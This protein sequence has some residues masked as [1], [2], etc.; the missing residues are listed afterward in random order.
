MIT[1]GDND[2]RLITLPLED[3]MLQ[4]LDK[5]EKIR[6]AEQ[7]KHKREHLI[8]LGSRQAT[9]MLCKTVRYLFSCSRVKQPSH[10]I[11]WQWSPEVSSNGSEREWASLKENIPSH[12]PQETDKQLHVMEWVSRKAPSKRPILR[13]PFLPRQIYSTLCLSL[14]LVIS[15]SDHFVSPHLFYK[16]VDVIPDQNGEAYEPHVLSKNY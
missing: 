14:G 16:C 6:S 4:L 11:N 2:R 1:P 15:R 3:A 8:L 7:P 13:G 10:Q 5:M 12:I 9:N